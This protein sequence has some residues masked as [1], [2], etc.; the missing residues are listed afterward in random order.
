MPL[1]AVAGSFQPRQPFREPFFLASLGLD[2]IA[3]LA[4]RQ[5]DRQRRSL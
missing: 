5:D 4:R 1:N 2:V 3:A